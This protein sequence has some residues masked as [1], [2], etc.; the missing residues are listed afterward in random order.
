MVA[1]VCSDFDDNL[2]VS[3][4]PSLL[5]YH[6]IRTGLALI[7]RSESISESTK[8]PL[9]AKSNTVYCTEDWDRSL[10][11]LV[12]SLNYTASSHIKT[13]SEIANIVH[14]TEILF[15]KKIYI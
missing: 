4:A 8:T 14:L 10:Q 2:P 7:Y 13:L 9:V 6:A 1:C 3:T 15:A 5:H 12:S 11:T